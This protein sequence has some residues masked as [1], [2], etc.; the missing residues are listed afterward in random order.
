MFTAC[1]RVDDLIDS[2]ERE[3]ILW[4]MLV[5]ISEVDAHTLL[6]SVFLQDQHW[7]GHPSRLLD[8]SDELGILQSM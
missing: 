8:F 6:V 3:V 4:A 2:R 5:E 7:F 1:H